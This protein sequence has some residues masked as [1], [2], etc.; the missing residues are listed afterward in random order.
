MVSGL[1]VVLLALGGYAEARRGLALALLDVLRIAL[2]LGIGLLAYSLIV[3][4]SN[5]YA[6]G[7]VTFGIAALAV[8][9][10][11]ALLARRSGL[12][13]RWGRTGASRVVAGA[14][15][16]LLGALIVLVLLPTAGRSPGLADDI[17]HAPLARPFVRLVPGIYSAA[18]F[19]NLEL[20]QLGRRAVR[21][22]DEKEGGSRLLSGRV[23]FTRLDRAM[24]IECRAAVEFQGYW[25]RFG[26]AVSP[27]FRCP[28]CGRTSD[29]CQT[30][31]G[32]HQMYGR[33]PHE[34]AQG[35]V[36]IDCGV[37][38]NDRPVQPRGR[39]PVCGQTGAGTARQ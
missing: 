26:L 14:I 8:V 18:D 29:G 33:C 17:L 34:V 2:G 15:G 31:E 23:N 27:R 35:K 16:L 5:S 39:C 22:E 25:L 21:F 11:L 9:W 20:P 38:P 10:L 32:F 4:L 28:N 6:A 1:I 13:P 12:D 24:C 30:F 19:T 37:W 36:A 7:L 3:R